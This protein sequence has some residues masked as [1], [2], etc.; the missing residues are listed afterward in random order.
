MGNEPSREEN[1]TEKQ[2]EHHNPPPPVVDGYPIAPPS[3]DACSGSTQAPEKNDTLP[4][5]DI[6]GGI[7]VLFDQPSGGSHPKGLFHF[8]GTD[9]N[10][11]AY[12]NPLSRG[13]C[14]V[15]ASSVQVGILPTLV[16]NSVGYFTTQEEP[17]PW[18]QVRLNVTHKF[19]P[20]HYVLGGSETGHRDDMMR[21]CVHAVYPQATGAQ[22]LGVGGLNGRRGVG[23]AE[24]APRGAVLHRRRAVLRPQGLAMLLT[25]TNRP[26]SVFPDSSHWSHPGRESRAA[27]I[28]VRVVWT[29]GGGRR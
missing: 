25:P 21:C 14:L 22:E 19:Y 11:E 4:R 28:W 16:E 8:L 27:C 12:F 2:P 10:K 24:G 29:P 20:D 6:P 13:R 1:T 18:F 23:A 7:P 9:M 26:I 15:T 3:Y 5:K 17:Q